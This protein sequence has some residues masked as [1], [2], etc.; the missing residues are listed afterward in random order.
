MIAA[1]ATYDGAAAE[2]P[3]RLALGGPGR[4]KFSADDLRDLR[5]RV[6]AVMTREG[7]TADELAAAMEVTPRAVF[8]S[9][10]RIRA[11][12]MAMLGGHG[13]RD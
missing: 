6:V 2:R 5:D 1:R 3:S 8:K 7:M 12:V 13:G 4:R 10:A 9:R 11:R